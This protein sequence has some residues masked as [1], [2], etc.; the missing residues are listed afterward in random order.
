MSDLSRRS[1][2]AATSTFLYIKPELVRGAGKEKLK[3]GVIGLGGRGR[4]AV[5]DL[6]TADE[7]AEF[8]AVAD[9]F[10]DKLEGNLRWLKGDPRNAAVAERVKVSPEHRFVGFDGYKKLLASDIDLV[11]L[12]T[13]P[14]YRPEHFEAAVEAKKHVFCEKPFGTDATGVRR[15]MA[16]AK[17]SEELKLTVVSGAQRRFASDY[18][19]TVDK[20]KNGVIGNVVATYAYWVG[21]PVIFQKSRNPKWGEMEWHHRNWYSHLWLCGDQIVEQ[22]LHNIDVINWV[23]DAHPISVAAHGG[24]VWRPRDEVHGS[25]YDHI[26]ADF[27]Y[28]NGVRMSSY[29]R[30]YPGEKMYRNVSELV[31]GTKGRSNGKDLGTKGENPYVSEHRA[32][33]ASIRGDGKYINHAMPVAESTLTC[34]MARE[35]AYSGLEI[36]WD[37]IMD[38]KQDL[39]PKAF[40]YKEK[41]P[42]TPFPV[43]GQYQFL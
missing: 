5:V 10:E 31:I 41:M 39:S 21:T 6:L 13:P 9:I 42:S 30:Q 17:K 22:H 3:A 27:I 33:V 43:P 7:T 19:E 35:S 20:I 34:I 23:M 24:A 2:L 40:G 14:G 32:L 29:C 26:S 1:M 28:P 37:M 18:M 16:A 11:I 4:Q 36:S 8:V 25:I 15:F 12:S 38:S